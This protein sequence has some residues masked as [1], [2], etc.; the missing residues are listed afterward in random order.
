MP[1]LTESVARWTPAL[2]LL[3]AGCGV[4]PVAGALLPCPAAPHC[5]STVDEDPDHHVNPLIFRGSVAQA[6]THLVEALKSLPR[7]EIVAEE[8][9]YLRAES[10]SSLMRF[11]DDVQCVIQ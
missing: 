2:V 3:L 5:V 7:T 10:H 9:R 4:G 6:R 8:P 1:N 11:V